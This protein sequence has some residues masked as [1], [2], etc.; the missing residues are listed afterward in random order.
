VA[1]ALYT[2]R[3]GNQAVHVE[4][5]SIRIQAGQQRVLA[6]SALKI[7]AEKEGNEKTHKKGFKI[8]ISITIQG[9][10]GGI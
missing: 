3:S 2:S 1:V 8:F 4:R 9:G 6:I 10:G 7:T 5:R